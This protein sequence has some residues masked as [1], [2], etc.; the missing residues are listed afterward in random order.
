M[1]E[2]GERG[3]QAAG[4]AQS[5]GPLRDPYAAA[6]PGNPYAAI[7]ELMPDLPVTKI[8]RIMLRLQARKL[9]PPEDAAWRV[10]RDQPE[11]LAWDALTLGTLPTVA[12]DEWRETCG[13]LVAGQRAEARERWMSRLREGSTQAGAALHVCAI[14]ALNEVAHEAEEAGKASDETMLRA[15]AWCTALLQAER[16]L[17][18]VFRHRSRIWVLKSVPD[19]KCA[20]ARERLEKIVQKVLRWGAGPHDPDVTRWTTAW[21]TERTAIL[22]SA[23]VF[24]RTAPPEWPVG[25]G[26][27]GLG[28]L[29]RE[30]AARTWLRTAAR[31]YGGGL[32]MTA[33]Q[34]LGRPYDPRDPASSAEAATL[35]QWAYSSLREITADTWAGQANLAWARL[36]RKAAEHHAEGAAVSDPWFGEGEAGDI[37][38]QRALLDLRAEI[39]LR[40]FQDTLRR[41][42]VAAR[43][44]CDTAADLVRLTHSLRKPFLVIAEMEKILCGRLLACKEEQR[45]AP[46]AEFRRLEELALEIRTLLLPCG[47]GLRCGVE[48]AHL[49]T[50]RA[51]RRWQRV[52][53]SRSAALRF[54]HDT[55][56]DLFRAVELAPHQVEIVTSMANLVLLVNALCGSIEERK[57]LVAR[58]V[59]AVDACRQSGASSPDLDEVHE[60][61]QEILDPEAA[62]QQAMRDLRDAKN[63]APTGG[64]DTGPAGP[65]TGGHEVSP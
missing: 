60:Q 13:R 58:A 17:F 27:L 49:L 24:G 29:G 36:G 59:G 3:E 21:E 8:N 57:R 5:P 35:L 53:K 1:K 39:L 44:V 61:L 64:P 62:F 43:T 25:F 14:L 11:R 15:I 16:W 48:L 46:A 55:L 45:R 40:V 42:E 4:D 30:Q 2:S 28:L 63:H 19:E 54:Q 38:R 50:A 41:P 18:D 26:P 7:P 6:L 51:A 9:A 65:R 32:P 47:A 23:R 31:S 56:R 33:V 20:E 22:I 34:Q 52:R 10:L 37:K 12:P